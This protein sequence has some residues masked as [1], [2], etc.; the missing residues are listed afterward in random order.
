M[1]KVDS[2]EVAVSLLMEKNDETC[3]LLAKEIETFNNERKGIETIITQQA[4]QQ[5]EQQFSKLPA[6][7][8]FEESEKWNPGVVGIVAGKLANLLNKP[9]VVLAKSGPDFKGSGRGVP[10]INLVN[11]LEKCKQL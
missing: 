11:C 7:V 4:L 5:A 1:R 10:G 6:V 9:C 3:S 8:A 2:P